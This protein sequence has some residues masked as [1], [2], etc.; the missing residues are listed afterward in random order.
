MAMMAKF[1]IGIITVLSLS[2]PNMFT[3]SESKSACPLW[4]VKQTG[5][6]K[7]VADLK[8]HIE[9]H[10]DSLLVYNIM[11]LTWDNTTDSL[12][13]GYCLYIPINYTLC[14]RNRYRVLS[15]LTGPELN[16]QICGRLNRQGAQCKQCISGH[17][18]AAMSDGV[19]CADCSTHKHFWILNLLV[20]LSCLT[21]M[22]LVI[23]VLQIK[24]TAMES[25]E[26]HHYLH[27][28]N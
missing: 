1:T 15:N 20:Q 9:C 10:K 27:V 14:K 24:G 4:H 7:C 25:M 8:G 11:C 21:I 2:S 23:M 17:G 18:P 19:S 26:Y 6:Y 5:K 16:K 22:F 12:H 28:V 3:I 13:A